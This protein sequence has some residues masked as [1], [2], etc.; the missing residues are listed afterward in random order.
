[1]QQCYFRWE[2]MKLLNNK[3]CLQYIFYL[4]VLKNV[5]CLQNCMPTRNNVDYVGAMYKERHFFLPFPFIEKWENVNQHYALLPI[6]ASLP[7]L[8][9]AANHLFTLMFRVYNDARSGET[10]ILILRLSNVQS[11]PKQVHSEVRYQCYS[12][13]APDF[14]IHL[15]TLNVLKKT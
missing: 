9:L 4:T 13:V 1:M 8:Y 11:R 5:I 14:T 7:W 12:S 15:S 2:K 10:S 6:Q 3:I